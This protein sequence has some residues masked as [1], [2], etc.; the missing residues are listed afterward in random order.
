[1]IFNAVAT[2]TAAI[3]TTSTIVAMAPI[4]IVTADADVC[5]ALGMDLTGIATPMSA[6]LTVKRHQ[7]CIEE[8]SADKTF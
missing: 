1:M 7:M 8:C 2:A 5:K 3:T 6:I 4:A